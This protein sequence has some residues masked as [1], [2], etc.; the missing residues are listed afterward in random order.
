MSSN[1]TIAQLTLAALLLG[2]TTPRATAADAVPDV[3]RVADALVAEALETNLGLVSV[4]AGVDQRLAALDIARAQFLPRIDLQLRYSEADGGREIVFPVGDL[5]NPVYSSLNSLLEA[6]GQPAPFTPIDN[7]SFSFLR[8]REQDSVVRLSQP[9]YDA[10]LGA[11]RRGAAHDYEAARHGLQA[12]RQRLVRDVRQAYYRWL[13]AREAVGVLE[14]TA[15]LAH[16]N[17]RVNESLHRNGKVTLDLKLRAE[18]ERLEVEQQLRRARATEALARRYL[19]L[20]CNAPLERTPELA[21]VTDADLPWLAMQIPAARGAALEDVAIGGRAELRQL[22]SGVAAA[23]EDERAARAAFKP[24]LALAVDAGTQGTDWGYGDHDPY[25]MASVIVRFNLF[26]GGGDRAGIRAARARS[27]G[28]AAG[29]ALAEQQI[30]IEVQQ[31]LSDLEV[32]EASLQTAGRRVD[33]ASAAYTIV[34]KKRDLGQVSPAEY[35]DAQR[36]L[37]QARLNGNVTRFEA[38]A[39]LAEVEYAIGGVEQQP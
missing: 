7:V 8:E 20:L 4:Q 3:Q 27:A 14:S 10:R 32:A 18:A 17:E 25:V 21:R 28:L 37:T 2:T 38:L 12:Y 29:R 26:S 24:Q 30:R 19:N 23:G 11:S 13:A 34:A 31:A 5:L 36:A 35:L 6:G 39:A 22:E 16:E 9:L 15:E 1:S 33:A